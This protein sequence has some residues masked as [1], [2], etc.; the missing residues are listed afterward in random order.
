MP[1]HSGLHNITL[2]PGLPK[3]ARDAAN[4]PLT[5]PLMNLFAGLFLKVLSASLY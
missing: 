4:E 3:N 2:I 1:P 5:H